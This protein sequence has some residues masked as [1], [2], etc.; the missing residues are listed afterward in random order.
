[1]SIER[2]AFIRYMRCVF[3]QSVMRVVMWVVLL[4]AAGY[5]AS[6]VNECPKGQTCVDAQK[7]KAKR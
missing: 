4:G 1:M 5:L 3:A 2:R 6:K 7:M